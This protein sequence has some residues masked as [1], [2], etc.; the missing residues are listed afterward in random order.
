MYLIYK[1]DIFC[2]NHIGD[3]MNEEFKMCEEII[4]KVRWY[5][6][7][8]DYAGLR[9]YLDEEEEKVEKSRKMSKNVEAEYIDSLVKDLDNT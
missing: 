7:R 9:L 5:M 1:I 8:K 4:K 3:S 6:E 2:Y